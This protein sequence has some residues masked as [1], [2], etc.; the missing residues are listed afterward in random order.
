MLT[1]DDER[2]VCFSG[3]LENNEECPHPDTETHIKD[4]S[5][6]PAPTEHTEKENAEQVR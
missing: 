2:C 6:N 5:Y 1:R 3:S 4:P